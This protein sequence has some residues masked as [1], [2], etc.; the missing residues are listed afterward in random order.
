M[1]AAILVEQNRPLVVDEVETP[2]TL[3]YGQVLIKVV[4]SSICGA[5]LNEIAGRKGPDK[6]L[7]HLLGHEGA[8]I[9]Q[10][11][12]AGVTTVK[13]GDHVVMHWRKGDGIHSPTPKYTWKGASINSGWV[14]TFN[15]YAVV[16][17][18]RITSIP[19]DFDMRIA[20]LYGCAVT[21]G[22]GVVH[23]DANL[24]SGESIVV[25]GV[26]GAG[27]SVILAASL[28]SAHPVIAVDIN[29][30]KL[31]KAQTFG[32]THVINSS[33]V[34]AREEIL[35]MFPEGVDVAVDGTGIKAIR[36]LCYEITSNEGCA[37]LVGVPAAKEKISI[38]SFPLHFT[39][40]ITG[41]HGG[42]IN[43]SYVIPRLLDLQKTGRFDLNEMI[44][45]EFSLDQ[46]NEALD[47]MRKGEALRCMLKIG[48]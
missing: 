14:T 38:D 44:T 4:Y 46:I 30:F 42:D 47:L 16:S 24:K 12:G 20:P 29:D 23:N 26:G 36:E 45:H 8:G 15:E 7:P 18:N 48:D 10:E 5:Q 21:T 34:D 41:S 13:E 33:K 25:F 31:K 35:K 37:V 6:F 32:A 43:P 19:K 22:Y 9:V 17:E 3:E 28:V 11:C 40:R 2:S 27:M 39:K 1:K